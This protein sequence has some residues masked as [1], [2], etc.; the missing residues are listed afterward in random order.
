MSPGLLNGGRT[1]NLDGIVLDAPHADRF[2]QALKGSPLREAIQDKPV[3]IIVDNQAYRLTDGSRTTDALANLPYTRAAITG[4]E[5]R[6]Y[7]PDD[8]TSDMVHAVVKSV[9]EFQS[10]VGVTDYTAPAFYVDRPDSPWA[11]VNHSLLKESRNQA[12]TFLYA[13]FCGSH[14]ALCESDAVSA[15]A[16]SGAL[17]AY[18]LASPLDARRNSIVKLV[19]YIEM[20]SEMKLR[21]LSVIAARQPAFGLLLLA[22]GISGFDGG[23]AQSET[24]DFKTVVRDVKKDESGKNTRGGRQ[25]PVYSPALL[26]SIPRELAA[27]VLETPGMR[28]VLRCDQPCC[29][30]SLANAVTASREH[31]VWSRAKEIEDIRSSH[32]AL[33]TRHVVGKLNNAHQN[34][35][36]LARAYQSDNLN[37]DHLERWSSVL[38]ATLAITEGAA[39]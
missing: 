23:I 26:T 17:G 6:G 25:R 19:K 29:R 5:S 30:D 21:G 4:D 18:V 13:T 24:F 27:R 9:L 3:Q 16:E 10:A 20:L 37:F 1:L 34:G 14:Q 28:S 39:R 33:R 32:P 15:I 7:V 11:D 35:A 22:A 2:S 12:G 31:F 8:F 38:E 36:R